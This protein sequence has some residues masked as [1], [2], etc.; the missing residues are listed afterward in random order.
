MGRGLER[1]RARAQPIY[2]R[3]ARVRDGCRSTEMYDH[4][5]D[6]S[7]FLELAGRERRRPDEHLMRCDGSGKKEPTREV[8]ARGHG[9]NRVAAA[10]VVAWRGGIRRGR[11][12][13]SEGYDETNLLDIARWRG[14]EGTRRGRGVSSPEHAEWYASHIVT[15]WPRRFHAQRDAKP[16]PVCSPSNA[17]SLG[18]D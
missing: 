17:Q 5:G 9:R 6:L 11:G 12:F 14:G 7:H 3:G 2:R 13:Q 4:G 1:S 16:C 15:M 18:G 8:T 10:T